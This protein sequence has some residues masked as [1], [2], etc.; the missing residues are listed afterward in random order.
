MTTDRRT[1]LKASAMAAAASGIPVLSQAAGQPHTYEVG[2]YYFPN[3]HVDARNEQIHGKGWTE[4]RMLQYAQPRFPGHRHPKVPLWGYE[5]ESIPSVFEKKIHAATDNGVT[6]F[7]FDWYWYED[8]PFLNAGLD[9]GYLGASNHD[10]VKFCLMWA[11]HDWVNLYPAKLNAPPWVQYKGGVNRAQFETITNYIIEKYFS[12]PSYFKVDDCPYFSVFQISHLIRSLGGVAEAGK[13]MESFRRRTQAAGHK[14]LH[15]N[16]IQSGIEVGDESQPADTRRMLQEIFCGSTTHYCWATGPTP[17]SFPSYDYSDAMQLAIP[18]WEKSAS[19]FSLP[20]YPNVSM[21]WDSTPRTCQSDVFT[22]WDYP[23][24]A[25]MTGNTPQRFKQA[26]EA[27]KQFL[28][29][30]GGSP[31]IMNVNAWNE[32]TEGSYL[33]PD[34]ESKMEYLNAIR[35]VFRG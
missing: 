28:D 27:A 23:F 31:R 8:R 4:W 13:A 14:D 5:D 34:A 17:K 26:L 7:I 9:Q 18:N 32:W 11:N 24:T 21:G 19:D 3:W 33:E 22:R 20:Y 6:Y 15:L 2:A 12:N 30:K 16:A 35:D 25:V 1:F 10:R 29:R